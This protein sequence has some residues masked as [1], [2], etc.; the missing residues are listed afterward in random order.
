[1]IFVITCAIHKI[2]TTFRNISNTKSLFHSGFLN[3]CDNEVEHFQKLYYSKIRIVSCYIT[4]FKIKKL[5][6]IIIGRYDDYSI[7]YF[8]TIIML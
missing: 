8:Q 1:M 3:S 4:T 2:C 6:N 5:P 7:D